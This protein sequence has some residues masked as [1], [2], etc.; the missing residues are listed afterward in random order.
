M[1]IVIASLF[2]VAAVSSAA[3]ACRSLFDARLPVLDVIRH[4]R[5]SIQAQTITI[6]YPAIADGRLEGQATRTSYRTLRPHRPRPAKIPSH[7]L[8]SFARARHAA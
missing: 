8:H 6:T 5:K 4:A 1:T 2:I 3:L 7:R